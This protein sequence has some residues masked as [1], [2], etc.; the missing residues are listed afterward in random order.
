MDTA[1][2][3]ADYAHWKDWPDEG[4]GQCDARQAAQFA[5]ELSRLPLAGRRP[6]RVLEIGYGNGAFLA[7]VRAQGHVCD[8]VELNPVL[9]ERARAQGVRVFDDI[10][11]VDGAAYDLI[12]AFDVC[13]HVP[14]EQ[15][16]AVVGAVRERLAP[17]GI[18]LLR[19]PNGDSP[20]SGLYQNGDITHRTLLGSGKLRQ[21]ACTARLNL[22]FASEPARA[23]QA[24]RQ[25]VRRWARGALEYLISRLYYDGQHV[26][27]DPTLV[28]ALRRPEGEGR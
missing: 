15:L 23:D 9:R 10:R 13:E 6:L 3:D 26:T 1:A 22:L 19:V 14:V 12:A 27:F 18:F 16:P 11:T 4:F 8:G 5:A 2:Y 24:L 21:L 25:R 7:W 28:A 17:G 20:F